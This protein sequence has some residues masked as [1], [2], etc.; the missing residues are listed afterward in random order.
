MNV[1][2]L[3]A[4]L[5][6]AVRRTTRLPLPRDVLPLSTLAMRGMGRGRQEERAFCI[7]FGAD[8]P[9]GAPLDGKPL[10]PYS[11]LLDTECDCTGCSW[12]DS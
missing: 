4:T 8:R 1:S 3:L 6:L 5:T 12:D 9:T 2:A 10:P 7:S 11:P